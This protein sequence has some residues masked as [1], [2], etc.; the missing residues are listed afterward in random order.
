VRA[1]TSH[2]VFERLAKVSR[3]QTTRLTHHGRKSGR[4]Y[5]VTIWFL[6]DGETVY[7]MT[8]NMRRQ[9]T[10]NVQSRPDIELAIGDERFRGRVEA[11]VSSDDEMQRVVD[12][13]KRKY[14]IARPYLWFKGRPDG[15][16]RVKL[17]AE[18]SESKS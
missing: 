13:M 9:W 12:L 11:V 2:D 3:R 6:V 1:M 14:L 5:Q 17:D 18:T 15:A 7:L 16:F 10:Q 8:M 4:P